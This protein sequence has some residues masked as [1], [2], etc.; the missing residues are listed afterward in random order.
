MDRDELIDSG[1]GLVFHI[2]RH[3]GGSEADPF[4]ADL[5]AAGMLALIRAAA[6]FDAARGT[7]FSTYAWAA[8]RRAC[9][10]ELR[11]LTSP[12]TVPA[13]VRPA[14]RPR[15]AAPVVDDEGHE[16]PAVELLAADAP[17]PEAL[18]ETAVVV[19]LVRQAVASLP[20]R[21]AAVVRTRYLGD[22]LRSMD[23]AGA[24]LGISRQ[25]VCQIEAR[26]FRGL[27]RMLT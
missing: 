26:A 18:A 24:V 7:S 2:A 13:G 14:Q 1:R 6:A 4:R 19:R 12:A 15:A 25:R 23:E 8:I 17:G 11:R 9:A 22:E 20:R 16:T 5:R 3:Y 21:D 10:H 27:R